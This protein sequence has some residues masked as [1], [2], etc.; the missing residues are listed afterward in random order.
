MA[1]CLT[2]DVMVL[3]H[4]RL[5]R[6]D[7]GAFIKSLF[8]H[9]KSIYSYTFAGLSLMLMGERVKTKISTLRNR[10]IGRLFKPERYWLH[11]CTQCPRCLLILSRENQN[12]VFTDGL[13]APRDAKGRYH[14]FLG[15]VLQLSVEIEGNEILITEKKKIDI[16]KAYCDWV[17]VRNQGKMLQRYIGE[18]LIGKTKQHFETLTDDYIIDLQSK[19]KRIRRNNWHVTMDDRALKMHNTICDRTFEGEDG[20][21]DEDQ[22]V[23]IKIVV[24]SE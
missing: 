5:A 2:T 22:D 4:P 3:L 20:E 8:V 12:H 15:Y 18:D 7:P 1:H 14:T 11:H 17:S 19:I 13:F 23:E 24:D 21:T 6:K 16:E 10:L 9:S